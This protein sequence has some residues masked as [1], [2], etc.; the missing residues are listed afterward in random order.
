MYVVIEGI[1][2]SGKTTV[3]RAIAR[4]IQNA[5]GVAP[6]ELCEPQREPGTVGAEIR[7]RMAEGPEIQQWEAVGLFTADRMQQLRDRLRPALEAGRVVV[8]DRSY[9]STAVYNG[10]WRGIHRSSTLLVAAPVWPDAEHILHHHHAIVPPPDLL[11]LLD[12]PVVT[13]SGRLIQKALRG[14]GRTHLPADVRRLEEWR[15]RYKRLINAHVGESWWR[16]LVRIDAS[17]PKRE[18]ITAAWEAVK[19]LVGPGP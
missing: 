6:I 7:R 15:D 11:V 19:P 13:A 18:V 12:L 10:D 8:Q 5:T 2:G 16:R 3:A 4:R 1:D 17:K 9:L 14:G